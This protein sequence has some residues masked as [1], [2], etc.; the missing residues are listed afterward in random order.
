MLNAMI[1]ASEYVGNNQ[2]YAFAGVL[3]HDV[4]LQ[5]FLQRH[6]GFVLQYFAG[7]AGS[8]R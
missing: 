2:Y 3:C 5:Q 6:E 1:A 7:I 4:H 8:R